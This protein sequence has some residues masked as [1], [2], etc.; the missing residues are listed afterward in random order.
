MERLKSIAGGR[1]LRALRGLGFTEYEASAY[2]TLLR[3]GRLTA[4]ELSEKAS[5]PYS[6]VYGVLESLRRRGWIEAG[7]GRPRVYYPKSPLEALR[8][9]RIRWER[10]F[11][12]HRSII[13][14]ELQPIY[15]GRGL[16]ERP[17]VW[18]IRG[19]DNILSSLRRIVEEARGE[20]MI[21]LPAVGEELLIPL[22]T[23]LSLLRDRGVRMLLLTTM[24]AVSKLGEYIYQF[25]EVRV[26]DEMFGGGIIA[27]GAETLLILDATPG[28]R[29][30]I[31]SDHKGL[32][33]IAKIYFNHLWRT[34]KPL[35][36]G[37]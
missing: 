11:E 12:E 8:V 37:Q 2:I 24:E 13:L 33:N 6:K 5:I 17:E 26:R 16:R 30:A 3:Y 36:L 25:H 29:L 28:G 34:A 27:D 4:L 21:A 23:S 22:S 7:E 32:T 15:E 35:K 10:S 31:A 1:S 18:I 14:E 20:L 19:L 9:E